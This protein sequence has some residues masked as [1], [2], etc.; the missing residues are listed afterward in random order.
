MLT[1]QRQIRQLNYQKTKACVVNSLAAI[2]DDQRFKD[3]RQK[4]NETQVSKSILKTKT[5]RPFD[6]HFQVKK[7]K[8][9]YALKYIKSI[10]KIRMRYRLKLLNIYIETTQENCGMKDKENAKMIEMI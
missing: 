5:F 1:W 9:L 7:V 4:V 3:F 6:D 8:F 10:I 2:F